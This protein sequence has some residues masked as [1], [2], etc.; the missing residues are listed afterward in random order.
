MRSMNR[1]KLVEAVRTAV[2]K[3]AQHEAKVTDISCEVVCTLDARHEIQE[4]W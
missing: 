2:F 4:E 3:Q 1:R